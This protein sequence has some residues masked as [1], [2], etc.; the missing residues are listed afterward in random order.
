MKSVHVVLVRSEYP[1]N[2][3]ASARAMANLGAGRLILVDPKC[4]VD[5][6]AH[7]AAAGAQAQLNGAIIYS[8]WQ[9]FYRHEGDGLRIALSR[10]HGK[11]RPSTPLPELLR[12]LPQDLDQYSNLYLIFGPEASGLDQDDLALV[13][14]C[15]TLPLNGEFTSLNLS[16][17]VLLTLFIVTQAMEPLVSKPQFNPSKTIRPLSFPDELIKQ[18]LIE[19]GFEIES[20]KTSAYLTLKRLLLKNLATA[21]EHRVLEAILQQTVRRLK[22]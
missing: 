14:G 1:S 2:I 19:L 15:C 16:Q 7:Q 18:W 10:R 5:H 9:E 11:S 13:T 20:R 22:K 8:S 6:S 4:E 3:G 12:E 17:A 21:H